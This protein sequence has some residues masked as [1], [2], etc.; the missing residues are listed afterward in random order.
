MCAVRIVFS[1]IFVTLTFV[2]E[3]F[4]KSADVAL[5]ANAASAVYFWFDR[6]KCLK[7]IFQLKLTLIKTF[8]LCGGVGRL[9]TSSILHFR[10]VAQVTLC[11][12]L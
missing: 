5:A 3:H 2:L 7:S 6:N 11:T 4:P 12:C 9:E 1:S 10:I 8:S